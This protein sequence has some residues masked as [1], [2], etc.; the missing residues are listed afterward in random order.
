MKTFQ[1]T[2]QRRRRGPG[3]SVSSDLPA[4]NRRT[5]LTPDVSLKETFSQGSVTTASLVAA[6]THKRSFNST[7]ASSG[8]VRNVKRNQPGLPKDQTVSGNRGN[9]DVCYSTRI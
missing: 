5:T 6:S 2:K 3:Q 8:S 4:P 7:A 1:L 9:G